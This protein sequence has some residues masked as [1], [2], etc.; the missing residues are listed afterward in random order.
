MK[1]AGHTSANSNV[2]KAHGVTADGK[3]FSCIIEHL[4]SLK[5]EA[6]KETQ[7]MQVIYEFS[8]STHLQLFYLINQ[9][10]IIE[11]KIIQLTASSK[12]QHGSCLFDTLFI[13]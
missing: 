3:K 8:S 9:D 13:Q 6:T 4:Y 12:L 5:H 11:H 10:V 7:R 2:H 1:T